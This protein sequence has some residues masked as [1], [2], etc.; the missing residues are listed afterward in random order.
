MSMVWTLL[1]MFFEMLP[2]P[3][4]GLFDY[5]P[6]VCLPQLVRQD[7]QDLRRD[8]RRSTLNVRIDRIPHL[9]SRIMFGHAA[10]LPPVLSSD[11]ETAVI[12][13]SVSG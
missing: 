9:H 10:A 13:A 1:R 3:R 2:E 5:C 6:R 12:S 11:N 8:P 7:F 4:C